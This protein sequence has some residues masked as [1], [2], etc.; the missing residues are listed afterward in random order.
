MAYAFD[1][2]DMDPACACPAT[3]V[4][5]VWWYRLVG[6]YGEQGFYLGEYVWS[7]DSIHRPVLRGQPALSS[8]T[9]RLTL[10][11]ICS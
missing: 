10:Y 8:M 9:V 5:S 3:L 6:G 11:S 7:L 4:C 1:L 2:L